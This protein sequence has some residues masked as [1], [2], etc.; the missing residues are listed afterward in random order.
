MAPKY[1]VS[2]APPS[3]P[4]GDPKARFEQQEKTM[5]PSRLARPRGAFRRGC[6]RRGTALL[7]GLVVSSAQTHVAAAEQTASQAGRTS[8]ATLELPRPGGLKTPVTPDDPID[9][10]P[11]IESPYVDQ[12]PLCHYLERG[13]NDHEP[14]KRDLYLLTPPGVETLADID[15]IQLGLDLPY[16]KCELDNHSIPC[17]DNDN[18]TSWCVKKLELFVGNKKLYEESDPECTR[19][20]GAGKTGMRKIDRAELRSHPLWSFEIDELLEMMSYRKPGTTKIE[21]PGIVFSAEYLSLAF[22]G[23][24]GDYVA[25]GNK[26]CSNGT[27][28]G[29]RRGWVSV[30]DDVEPLTSFMR[31]NKVD[32]DFGN[33]APK[34]QRK[35]TPYVEVRGVGGNHLQV[36]LDVEIVNSTHDIADCIGTDCGNLEAY[37]GRGSLEFELEFPCTE[38]ARTNV[39][40]HGQKK[41]RYCQGDTHSPC[42]KKTGIAVGSKQG[43]VQCNDPDDASYCGASATLV[44]S[45]FDLG[46]ALAESP[47]FDAEGGFL[48][49]LVDIGCAL[50]G[51]IAQAAGCNSDDVATKQLVKNIDTSLFEESLF[52]DL[53]GCPAV[54]IHAN[55]DAHF[56][57]RELDACPPGGKNPGC[58]LGLKGNGAGAPHGAAPQAGVIHPAGFAPPRDLTSPVP[59]PAPV[60]LPGNLIDIGGADDGDPLSFGVPGGQSAAPGGIG[61]L[62]APV[63]ASRSLKPYQVDDLLVMF[64]AA[65]SACV[66]PGFDLAATLQKLTPEQLEALA[67]SG[68]GSIDS[69][70][71]DVLLGDAAF[72]KDCVGTTSN[73]ENVKLLA[74]GGWFANVQANQATCEETAPNVEDLYPVPGLI[75]AITTAEHGVTDQYAFVNIRKDDKPSDIPQGTREDHGC[76]HINDWYLP[77]AKIPQC[78][79][80]VDEDG[81]PCGTKVGGPCAGVGDAGAEF[82]EDEAHPNGD[83]SATTRCGFDEVSGDQMACVSEQFDGA[84]GGD[85]GVCR[86]CGVPGGE[87]PGDFTMQGCPVELGGNP[88]ECPQDYLKGADGRCWRVDTGAPDWECQADCREIY[89]DSGY[90]FHSGAWRAYWEDHDPYVWSALDEAK[91]EGDSY[92]DAI[93]ADWIGCDEFGASCAA[94]GEACSYDQCETECTNASSCDPSSGFPLRYPA[95]FICT[96]ENTCQ[97]P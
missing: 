41:M 21:P 72:M 4:R 95:G 9:D 63:D 86:R 10:G 61:D 16:T 93:C 23:I 74:L 11:V 15:H 68:L 70:V 84:G 80:G 42:W 31:S 56:D 8:A 27:Y 54:S 87:S 67:T 52:K 29:N 88:Y 2:T 18:T 69:D 25:R 55:G 28:C 38:K 97:L 24:A 79:N 17:T 76:T 64:C 96:P 22:E 39:T 30:Q 46:V 75:L 47:T 62:T 1:A 40:G 92:G 32:C 81:D 20:V 73:V 50:L 43:V 45:R 33:C 51:P 90:C 6:G 49:T 83:W 94:R 59:T 85:G 26:G 3:L 91:G 65:E 5:F 13:L 58:S 57:F 89:G 36:D 34:A 60:V 35:S 14:G 78:I 12:T 82:Y 71:R 44:D 48:F 19:N 77:G 7:L 53:D 37:M 66:D